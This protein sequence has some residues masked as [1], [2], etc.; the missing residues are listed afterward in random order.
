MSQPQ[1]PRQS[2]AAL[3]RSPRVEEPETTAAPAAPAAEPVQ[4]QLRPDAGAAD[5]ATLPA[6]QAQSLDPVEEADPTEEANPAQLQPQAQASEAP[7]EAVAAAAV[8]EATPTFLRTHSHGPQSARWQWALLAVL[9]LLLTLQVVLADRARLA[10]NP[11]HRP[12]LESLCGVLGCNLPLWQEPEAFNMLARSVL[13]VPDQPGTLQVEASFRNDARFEQALPLIELTLSTADGQVSGQRI[14]TPAEYLGEAGPSRL[15]P[16]QSAQ[17]RFQLVE[18][19][20]A[21]EAFHFRFR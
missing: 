8:Q 5:T 15:A 6:G 17:A 3:L 4:L 14:F 1:P 7:A 11:S 18:P 21:A 9:A 13:P 10:S 19:E 20:P 12:W 16:G 2:L